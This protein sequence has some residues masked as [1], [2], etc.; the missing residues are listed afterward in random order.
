MKLDIKTKI[1]RKDNRKKV[2][3]AFSSSDHL[4][5]SQIQKATS[6]SI[7]TVNAVINDMIK[8]KEI[9]I[10]NEGTQSP[11]G[12]PAAIYEYNKLFICGCILYAYEKESYF[13]VKTVVTNSFGNYIYEK[14]EH[15]N[16]VNDSIL[17]NIL[18]SLS[19]TYPTIRVLTLGFPGFEHNKVIHSSDFIKNIEEG[20]VEKIEKHFGLKVV[21]VN[22]INAATYGYYKSESLS[23]ENIV[24]LFFPKHFPPGSG[25]IIGGN[26]Y[27]GAMNFAGEVCHI[28]ASIPWNKLYKSSYQEI[29][30]QIGE[31][32]SVI[33]CVLAPDTIVLYSEYINDNIVNELRLLCNEKY[34]AYYI[35]KIE[36]CNTLDQNIN[37]GLLIITQ[38]NIEMEYEQL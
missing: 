24:G 38:K 34:G 31:L 19:K 23:T 4:S 37:K 27:T 9:L 8:D 35:P 32:L 20:F 16:E 6:L 29:I 13:V 36:L 12:R 7:V 28:R 30:T 5:A 2:R 1:I 26:I 21:Y 22:E 25:I 17:V 11:V 3:L 14:E 10:S 33:I 15:I 18:E